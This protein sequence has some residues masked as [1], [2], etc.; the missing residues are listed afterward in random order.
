MGGRQVRHHHHCQV[1]EYLTPSDTLAEQLAE[2][3]HCK[4]QETQETLLEVPEGDRYDRD[5]LEHHTDGQELAEL[6]LMV[7]YFCAETPLY[8]LYGQGEH[9]QSD[10]CYDTKRTST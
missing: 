7:S 2:W 10:H 1:D 8:A 6:Y 5:E 3:A 9:C 4:E